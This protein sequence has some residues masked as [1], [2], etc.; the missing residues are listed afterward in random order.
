M[1]LID[2][3]LFIYSIQ[4][5]Y[6]KLQEFIFQKDCAFSEISIVECLGYKKI[7]EM[8]IE[9]FNMCFMHLK[10]YQISNF[11]LQKA[12]TLKQNKKM[13]IADSVIAATAI[14]Y[15]MILYTNNIKDYEHINSLKLMNPII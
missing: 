12:A 3:N 14:Q 4:P 2:S 9:Y 5:E 1:K 8:E 15:D 7:L 11:I 10:A 13:S 6:H